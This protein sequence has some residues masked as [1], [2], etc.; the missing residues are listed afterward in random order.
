MKT[1]ATPS[2]PVEAPYTAANLLDLLASAGTVPAKVEAE[3]DLLDARIDSLPLNTDEY[4]FAHNWVS[5]ARELARKGECGAARYQ[6]LQVC[7]KL[8]LN[9]DE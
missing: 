2:V 1:W 6:V 4:G 5:N 3:F 7:R 9:C 8:G